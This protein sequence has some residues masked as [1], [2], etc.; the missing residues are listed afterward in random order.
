MTGGAGPGWAAFGLASLALAAAPG[1]GVIY[2]VTRTLAQGRGAGLAS[3]GGVALGNLGNALL[4]SLALALLRGISPQ[5]YRVAIWAGAAYLILLGVQ[6]WR[7]PSVPGPVATPDA[8]QHRRIFRDGFAVAILNPKT[9]LFFAAFLPRFADPNAPPLQ[10][11]LLGIG[12]VSIAACSDTGYVLAASTV[13]RAL[14]IGS[15]W[16]AVGRAVTGA[17]YIGL[18][19]TAAFAGGLAD[20]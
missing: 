2:I 13:G 18:G 9:A 10:I 17:I 19:L 6:A 5:A 11:V 8:A 4:G 12:F 14:G 7:A 16:R 15:R 3:V 1:P 20:R